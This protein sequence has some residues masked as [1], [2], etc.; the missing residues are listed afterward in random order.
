MKIRS[1]EDLKKIKE[2]AQKRIA[3][4]EGHAEYK[5]VVCMGTCGIA[6]GARQVMAAILDEISKRGLGNVAV[7]QAGCVGLCD[8]EPLASVEKG[9]EKVFYGDL[10]PEKARQIVATH[11]V[12][13]QIQGE[14]VVHVER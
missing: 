13:G 14:W 10:N 6:S 1:L 3:V 2:E 7:S 12:N 8:R 9:S 4:R 11:L 5:V